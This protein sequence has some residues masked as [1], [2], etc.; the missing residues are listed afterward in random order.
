MTSA[1]H[2]SE[3]M[4]REQLVARL[5][6]VE[7]YLSAARELSQ[8]SP[9]HTGASPVEQ[10]FVAHDALRMLDRSGTPAFIYELDHG[11]RVLDANYA[12]AALTGYFGNDLWALCL[13]DLLDLPPQPKLFRMLSRPRPKGFVETGIWQGRTK[14]NEAR[15]VIAS[16]HDLVFQGRRARF[17]VLHSAREAHDPMQLTR[18]LLSALPVAAYV[19]D[20][21]SNLVCANAA[22]AQLLG[23]DHPEALH[24]VAQAQLHESS[25]CVAGHTPGTWQDNILRRPDGSTL[26]LQA[27]TAELDLDGGRHCIVLL[28]EVPAATLAAETVAAGVTREWRWQQDSALRFSDVAEESLGA[29]AGEQGW[30]GKSLLELPVRWLSLED[31]RRYQQAVEHHHPF[32]SVE[33]HAPVAGNAEMALLLSGGPLHDERGNF[34]GY[35]GMARDVT[36]RRTQ[37]AQLQ[38]LASL[39]RHTEDAVLAL[40]TDMAVVS[41][42]PG[43]RQLLGYARD[44]I[45]GKRLNLLCA[46][47]DAEM[48]EQV[49]R[50]ARGGESFR[51]RAARARHRDGHEVPV[52]ATC[53]PVRNGT[54]RVVG[55]ALVMRDARHTP[56]PAQALAQENAQLRTALAAAQLHPWDLDLSEGRMHYGDTLP[57]LLG[58]E[59]DELPEHE[60]PFASVIE[61]RDAG[62]VLRALQAVQDSSAAHMD[63]VFRAWKKSGEQI[64]LQARARLV[65]EVD[66]DVAPRILGTCADITAA[67][68]QE[69]TRRVLGAL[70]EAAGAV[71]FSLALDGLILSWSPGAEAALGYR[72]A[73]IVG[74]HHDRLLPEESRAQHEDA[75]RQL[76]EGASK[77]SLTALRR[78][79]NASVVELDCVLAPIRDDDGALCEIA[80][81]G[82]QSHA[83]LPGIAGAAV[84]A[85]LALASP[86]PAHGAWHLARLVESCRDAIISFG[87]EGNIESFNLGAE[88]L[89]GYE[90]EEVIAQPLSKVF[91]TAFVHTAM[92]LLEPADAAQPLARRELVLHRRDGAPLDLSVDLFPLVDEGRIVGAACLLH[93][94]S[95]QRRQDDTLRA[96]E[97]RFRSLVEATHQAVWI[98][99]ATGEMATENPSWL[100][101]TGQSLEEARGL[102]WFDALH[103]EDRGHALMRWQAAVASASDYE[104]PQRVLRADGQWRDMIARAVPV[105]DAQGQLLEWIG[106]HV[107]ITEQRNTEDALRESEGRLQSI[108]NSAAEGI[109]VVDQEGCIERMNIAAQRMFGYAPTD[110][111]TLDLKQLIVELDREFEGEDAE[112]RYAAWLRRMIGSQRDLTGQG[113]DGRRF[114]LELSVNEVSEAGHGTRFV[115]IVR[116]VTERKSWEARIFQL[117]YSDSLTGLPNRLLLVDRLEQA[118]AGAQRNRT[119]VGVLFFDF[120]G[121]KQV[122]DRYGHHTGDLLLKGMSERIRNC[123]REIDTVSRLGGDEFVVVLP[124]LKDGADAGAVARKI[125]AA[126]SQPYS[127]EHQEIS[128]TLTAGISVYPG[129]GESAE[130]LI[131]H[132]DTAMY[133][134]KESGKNRFRFFN[135]DIQTLLH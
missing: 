14:G 41:W 61:A 19:V 118:V 32:Q 104:C 93:D 122:N 94:L 87:P 91:D 48:L 76:R 1:M 59:P 37:D 88:K 8:L 45:L 108:L 113:H 96:G 15:Q 12:F 71:I 134:A 35:H 20:P 65:P 49:T 83:R 90:R 39:L 3:D 52:A 10:D 98:A 18:T 130:V 51:Q 127:I 24:G 82:Q 81:M 106:I 30:I 16:G 86:G 13:T 36:A 43:A 133:F 125:I 47:S 129:D 17:V 112:Q 4:T 103:P 110:Y 73:E 28:R 53:S 33:L 58:Y 7:G 2:N 84:P 80:I 111:A 105:R 64:W 42:N 40:S 56:L 6:V 132:A 22:A 72:A 29:Q 74:N 66:V 25:P 63:T 46:D 107:D 89:L 100:R 101:Y 44:E 128:I 79:R 85:P 109:V 54:S 57:R 117:A 97:A 50:V 124:E 21:E 120:D 121:F 131:R 23:Y 78:H 126:L 5:R 114:P 68:H 9:E 26:P 123:V 27:C 102:G 69:N 70:A 95:A 115:A 62:R 60:G 38:L 67:K 116:D 11:L 135:P 34:L 119:Q 99:N 92:A 75:L 77:V 31:K 55:L